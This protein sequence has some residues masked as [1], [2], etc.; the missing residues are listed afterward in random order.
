[1]D[2][3]LIIKETEDYNIYMASYFKKVGKIRNFPRSTWPIWIL[4]RDFALTTSF[5]SEFQN[6]DDPTG[7][8]MFS[9]FGFKYWNSKTVTVPLFWIV[10]GIWKEVSKFEAR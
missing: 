7:E 5:G 10:C 9:D 3:L 6:R 8:W 2:S 1:M 4:N